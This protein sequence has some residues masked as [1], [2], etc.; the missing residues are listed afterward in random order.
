[1][2]IFQPYST[3]RFQFAQ[4]HLFGTTLYMRIGYPVE[5]RVKEGA[6]WLLRRQF[7][8]DGLCQLAEVGGLG[9]FWILQG[10]AWAKLRVLRRQ[11]G[12]LA[13]LE[14]QLAVAGLILV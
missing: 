13:G 9:R 1:M 3:T 6:R 8:Y 7:E 2:D 10:E 11:W 14:E 5:S 12:Q 4:R